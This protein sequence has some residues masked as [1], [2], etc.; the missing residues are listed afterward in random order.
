MNEGNDSRPV[1]HDTNPRH[2]EWGGTGLGG[3]VRRIHPGTGGQKG[4]K[5]ARFDLIPPVALEALAVHYG[6]GAAKYEDRNWEKGYDWSL[7]FAA[8]QRHLWAFWGGDEEDEEGNLHLAAAAFH[9]FALLHFTHDSK[10]ESMD[11]RP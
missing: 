8:L 3:E 11:D 7:S 4:Q 6:K 10:Y 5:L 9:V 1:H 2:R